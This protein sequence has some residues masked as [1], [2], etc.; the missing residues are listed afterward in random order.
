MGEGLRPSQQS[1][2]PPML[3][4]GTR[5]FL[6]YLSYRRGIKGRLPA[7]LGKHT[8]ADD[9]WLWVKRPNEITGR[10]A[11]AILPEAQ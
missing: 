1:F 9:T 2:S 8:I 6:S 11:I 3:S 10:A 5:T 7:L 4:N